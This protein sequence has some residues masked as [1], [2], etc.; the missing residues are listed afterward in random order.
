MDKINIIK[1]AIFGHA[2]A[3]ALG[4]PVEFNSREYLKKNPVCEMMGYGTYNQPRGTWSDDTSMTLCTLESIS[5]MRKI[6]L[7]D[8]MKRFAKWYKKGYMT[9]FND[10]FD[11]GGTTLTA[12]D[13]FLL[14]G[15]FPY[16]MDGESSNGNGS[17]MRI[18]PISLYN[19]FKGE[20]VNE[21]IENIHNVSA[22]THAHKR[23]LIGCGIYDFVIRE[24]ITP[25]L[26]IVLK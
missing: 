16:G 20:G 4:V 22:L 19:C 13:N 8:I 17:L 18:I 15:K 26:L 7:D 23:S 11:I 5:E 10:C 6:V 24:L 1:G 3:D 14:G 12:I 21:G 25:L 2:V 9:P